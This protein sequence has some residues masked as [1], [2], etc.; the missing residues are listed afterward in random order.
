ME[1]L[2]GTSGG[3]NITGKTEELLRVVRCT[4]RTRKYEMA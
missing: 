3:M 2:A 1:F 4:W